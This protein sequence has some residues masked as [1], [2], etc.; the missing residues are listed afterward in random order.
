MNHPDDSPDHR[1]L[2]PANWLTAPKRYWQEDKYGAFTFLWTNLLL[3]TMGIWAPFVGVF[4]SRRKTYADVA[5]EMMSS[6][7]LYLFVI[8][9]IASIAFSVF[10]AAH[11]AKSNNR[12]WRLDV[13]KVVLLLIF[14]ACLLLM[15]YQIL[16]DTSVMERNALIQIL[17]SLLSA[18]AGVYIF[19][20]LKLDVEE[21]FAEELRRRAE[22]LRGEAGSAASNKSD[23]D[24]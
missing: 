24:S 19:C 12:P 22:E 10:T 21:P 18:T 2:L 6:G 5:N 13:L 4:L 8:P 23:F 16:A 20:L 1:H 3:G 14:A 11:L 9:F 17:V 15:P 7:A